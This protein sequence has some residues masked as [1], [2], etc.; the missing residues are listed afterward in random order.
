VQVLDKQ[1]A[2]IAAL[3][4]IPVTASGDV[5]NGEMQSPGT[6]SKSHYLRS[7]VS[8]PGSVATGAS[9]ASTPF[10]TPLSSSSSSAASAQRN[11]TF[12]YRSPAAIAASA[13]SAAAA[14]AAATPS[15]SKKAGLLNSHSS[16]ATPGPST[17]V[18]KT[19]LNTTAKKGLL[20][21]RTPPPTSFKDMLAASRAGKKSTSSAETPATPAA[22]DVYEAAQE[23]GAKENEQVNKQ[24]LSEMAFVVIDEVKYFRVPFFLPHILFT[25]RRIFA[26]RCIG[27]RRPA[28]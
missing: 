10:A 1:F 3:R 13:A 28:E 20:G 27:E 6:P 21:G 25:I 17:P 24:Y 8:T 18:G 9:A 12:A 4:R 16:T 11:N 19:P 26:D 22:T 7:A 2:A 5:N 14:S 15:T 23:S